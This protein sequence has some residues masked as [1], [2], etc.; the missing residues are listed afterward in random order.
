MRQGV[1]GGWGCFERRDRNG[2]GTESARALAARSKERE[3]S[4][5]A[6]AEAVQ[7]AIAVRQGTRVRQAI[8]A[9]SVTLLCLLRCELRPQR[10]SAALPREVLE[11]KVLA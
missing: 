5:T 8:G 7:A 10:Q 4:E 2:D 3:N 9:V 11:G 1:D 6:V